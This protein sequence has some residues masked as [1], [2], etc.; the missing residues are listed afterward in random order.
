MTDTTQRL[1]LRKSHKLRHK[2][3]ID[4][5]FEHGERL[6][7]Y[8]LRLCWRAL[9]EGELNAGFR[10]GTPDRIA[11]DQILVSIPK[12]KLRHA[13]D[14]VRM[15]RVV[16]EAYRLNAPILREALARRKDI[17]TVSLGFVYLS[18]SHFE[19]AKIESRMKKLLTNLYELLTQ[20][21]DE[22]E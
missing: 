18:D 22:R 12:R 19:Y 17:R 9:G 7:A 14:R 21:R 13:V 2:S 5:L 3:L 1:T 16:R 6:N 11:P 15:R 20:G 10:N 8:P 4:A